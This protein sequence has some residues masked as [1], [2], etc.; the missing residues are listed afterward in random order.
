MSAS[1]SVT[2]GS[3]L[4]NLKKGRRFT[5]EPVARPVR[6]ET[7]TRARRAENGHA[8]PPGIF[9]VGLEGYPETEEGMAAVREPEPASAG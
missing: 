2:P 3:R 5:K 7:G 9:R 4:F 1:A 6:H 8:M